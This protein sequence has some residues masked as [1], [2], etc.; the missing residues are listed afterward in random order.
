[1]NFHFSG[2]IHFSHHHKYKVF[3]SGFQI[4][5][6]KYRILIGFYIIKWNKDRTLTY[7]NFETVEIEILRGTDRFKYHLRIIYG[8]FNLKIYV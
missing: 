3:K 8:Q 4:L 2:C 6:S 1:M 5:Y 7:T